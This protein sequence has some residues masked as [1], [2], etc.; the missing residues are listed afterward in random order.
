[1]TEMCK[2]LREMTP[3]RKYKSG[4]SCYGLQRASKPLNT[5]S[6]PSPTAR[7]STSSKTP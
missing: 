4:G 5:A 3:Q 6:K 2:P 1:M 7:N